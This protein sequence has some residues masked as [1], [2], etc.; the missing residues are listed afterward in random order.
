MLSSQS[1]CG[2]GVERE[3]KERQPR[4]MPLSNGVQPLRSWQKCPSSRGLAVAVGL[5][6]PPLVLL[7]P[8]LGMS[9]GKLPTKHG[10]VGSMRQAAWPALAP[11]WRKERGYS[12]ACSAKQCGC[13]LRRSA[14]MPLRCWYGSGSWAASVTLPCLALEQHLVPPPARRASQCIIRPC[15]PAGA[16]SCH[17]A[18]HLDRSLPVAARASS[19]LCTGSPAGLGGECG[20]A[21]GCDSNRWLPI[22]YT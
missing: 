11:G 19:S 9:S 18:G 17:M 16:Y 2:C 13:M 5:S 15:K 4:L 20:L 22:P 21:S 1:G 7:K 3:H 8:L 10:T 14:S 12:F 6:G